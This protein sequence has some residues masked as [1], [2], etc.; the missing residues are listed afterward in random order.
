MKHTRDKGTIVNTSDALALDCYVD[1]DRE[2]NSEPT[3][4]LS[5]TGFI[6]LNGNCPVIWR[7][8]LQAQTTLSSMHAEYYVL[9]ATLRVVLTLKKL[10][11]EVTR[12]WNAGFNNCSNH[13]QDI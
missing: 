4:I 10:L 5:H 8:Q 7:S 9:S 13:S 12:H 6:I 1:A 3:S 11:L 2:P